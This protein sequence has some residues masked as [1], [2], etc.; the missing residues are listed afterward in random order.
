[1]VGYVLDPYNE[2]RRHGGLF[3]TTEPCKAGGYKRE[4]NMRTER[5]IGWEEVRKR[6]REREWEWD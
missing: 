6:K 2:R 4:K 5:Q 1:M 3:S